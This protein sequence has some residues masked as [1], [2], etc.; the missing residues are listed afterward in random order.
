MSQRRLIIPAS[1]RSVYET[2][3]YAPGVLVK[4]TLY[5][6]GQ[7]GRDAQLQL[8]EAKEAQFHQVFKKYAGGA[9]RGGCS[10]CGYRRCHQLPHGYA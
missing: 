8:V 2:V 9:G 1:M 4:D 5:I 7:I 10:F 3:G 6:S